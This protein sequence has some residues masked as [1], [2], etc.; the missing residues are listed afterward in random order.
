[1]RRKS[2]IGDDDEI[3]IDGGS[4]NA[5]NNDCGLYLDQETYLQAED[6]ML[7]PDGS[8]VL[9][10]D[11]RRRREGG[12]HD[13]GTQLLGHPPM[14]MPKIKNK[15]YRTAVEGLFS[16]PPSY[17]YSDD[18]ADDDATNLSESQ[19]Q[20]SDDEILYRTV[21][22]IESGNNGG[23]QQKQTP[24][25]LHDQV[26]AEEKTYLLQS[27]EFRKSLSTPFDDDESESHMARERREASDRY[28]EKVLSDVLRG[29][30]EMVGMAIS[31]ED[32]MERV[33]ESRRN[34]PGNECAKE[35]EEVVFCSGC[36]CR[37][38]PDM[39][40][41]S[42][43]MAEMDVGDVA[44]TKKKEG[45][46]DDDAIPNGSNDGGMLLCQACHGRQ[47]RSSDEARVRVATGSQYSSSSARKF[48][49]N[50]NGR[51]NWTKSGGGYGGRRRRSEGRDDGGEGRRGGSVQGI[52]T[53]S[54]FEVPKKGYVV[55]AEGKSGN[56]RPEEDPIIAT[57]TN[58]NN[59][60]SSEE[61]R[62][63]RRRSTPPRRTTSRALGGGAELAKRMQQDSEP[64][65]G[66][67]DDSDQQQQT[68]QKNEGISSGR[69]MEQVG[70]T[71]ARGTERS[72]L[73]RDTHARIKSSELGYTG[74]DEITN[75]STIPSPNTPNDTKASTIL[76][77]ARNRGEATNSNDWVKVEDPGSK[78]MLYW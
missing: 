71:S 60:L 54:L 70:S 63:R 4:D 77:D 34:D 9:D 56:K 52:S 58:S 32:A 76:D 26:F 61:G 17:S 7:R 68:T 15:T 19:K 22:D 39:I 65:G 38:T 12:Y 33:A 14:M 27:E 13:D 74:G 44:K 55:T 75:D 69:K 3:T 53:S 64:S 11:E 21:M 73:N 41:R 42:K 40:R 30:D 50:N 31:R 49:R 78:R 28:N 2:S 23:Q 62:S 10:A 59:T 66:T 20:L 6:T 37:V 29:I 36:G 1:M 25:D 24:E 46:G 18:D 16:P 45:T 48:D 43:E 67:R 47:F 35:D 51:R 57:T 5:N 8:L 72:R